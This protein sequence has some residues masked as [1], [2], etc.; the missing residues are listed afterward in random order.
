MKELLEKMIKKGTIN[1]LYVSTEKEHDKLVSTLTELGYDIY[2]DPSI[3]I[4]L[5]L[6]ATY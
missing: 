5:N 1:V 3:I 6:I 4:L 2:H